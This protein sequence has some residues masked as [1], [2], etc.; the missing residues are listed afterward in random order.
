MRLFGRIEPGRGAG[1]RTGQ[2]VCFKPARTEL[3]SEMLSA[4]VRLFGC[5]ATA[6]RIAESGA[7]TGF[8]AALAA[9]LGV[10]DLFWNGAANAVD[11]TEQRSPEATRPDRKELSVT[12]QF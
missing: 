11:A 4:R 8:G 9:L 6:I 10:A 12:P 2:P 1:P 7:A 3:T 5:V